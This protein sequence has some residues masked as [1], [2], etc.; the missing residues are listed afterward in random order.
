MIKLSKTATF[1][2][3]QGVRDVRYSPNGN[4]LAIASWSK[5]I[6]LLDT[7]VVLIS[8]QYDIDVESDAYTPR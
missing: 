6:T 3:A 7:Q 2:N 5:S 8:I 4:L 1:G